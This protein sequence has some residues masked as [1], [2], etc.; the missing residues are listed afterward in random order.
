MASFVWTDVRPVTRHTYP[1]ALMNGRGLVVTND[2]EM[3]A[4]SHRPPFCYRVLKYWWA[5]LCFFSPR[6]LSQIFVSDWWTLLFLLPDNHDCLLLTKAA[7]Q[8]VFL[9][10]PRGGRMGDH[11][12][13]RT[14]CHYFHLTTI[15]AQFAAFLQS[16]L[17]CRLCFY[18]L[19][20]T[21]SAAN[22]TLSLSPSV[23]RLLSTS[24]RL[25]FIAALWRSGNSQVRLP[26]LTTAQNRRL[27]AQK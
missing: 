23:L 18:L 12:A 20:E 1:E 7:V 9:K 2:T 8:A 26:V 10:N 21:R 25:W 27:I 3:S 16:C 17:I 15:R 5:S 4:R 11:P 14:V 24:P 13:M 22:S 19:D 6:R